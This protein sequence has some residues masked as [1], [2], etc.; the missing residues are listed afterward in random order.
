MHP[1][2]FESPLY[3]GVKNKTKTNLTIKNDN[4]PIL[5][6]QKQIRLTVVIQ[7]DGKRLKIS[8][9][10]LSIPQKEISELAFLNL[11]KLSLKEGDTPLLEH[12]NFTNLT[13]SI[14]FSF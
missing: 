4:I 1:G 3:S 7:D 10:L 14:Y 12:K 6:N 5:M 8:T 11:A 13:G 2:H 9:I